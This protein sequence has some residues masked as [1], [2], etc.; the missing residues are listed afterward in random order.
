MPKKKTPAAVKSPYSDAVEINTKSLARALSIVGGAVAKRSTLPVLGT[1]AFEVDGEVVRLSATNLEVSIQA[2]VDT[3]RVGNPPAKTCLP[4]EPFADTVRSAQSDNVQFSLSAK[5]VTSLIKAGRITASIKGIDGL[6]APLFPIIE[7]DYIT[8]DALALKNAL[9][10]VIPFAANDGFR[11]TLNGIMMQVKKDVLTIVGLDGFRL[12][13]TE[14]V[15]TNSADISTKSIVLLNA[16]SQLARI[17]PDAG[18]VNLV[19][20]SPDETKFLATMGAVKL[21][22]ILVEGTYPDYS[23]MVPETAK[24]TVT[25]RA[26]QLV[27]ALKLSNIL[28]DQQRTLLRTEDGQL[29]IE[30]KS[31]SGAFE[32]RLPVGIVGD[33]LDLAVNCVYLASTLRAFESEV[34][35]LHFNGPTSGILVTAGD[36]RDTYCLMMPMAKENS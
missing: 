10:R 30:A 27:I 9:R 13:K 7:S 24:T 1:I 21:A 5:T 20:S 4:A 19:L 15:A 18:E 31:E 28:G 32:A 2:T 16:V 34:V 14:I 25:A 35:T 12:C 26:D 23:V 6:E 11:P 17:L 3:A 33:A 29:V 8:V 22:A 36:T